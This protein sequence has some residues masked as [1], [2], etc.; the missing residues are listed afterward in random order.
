[1]SKDLDD[2]LSKTMKV[3]YTERAN[4]QGTVPLT[5]ASLTE[6]VNLVRREAGHFLVIEASYIPDNCYGI[7]YL[8]PEDAQ[9]MRSKSAKP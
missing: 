4:K 1:V 9:L 7:I 2:F 8:R 5:A 3:D 6:M